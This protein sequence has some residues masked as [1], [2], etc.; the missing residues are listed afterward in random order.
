MIITYLSLYHLYFIFKD[1]SIINNELNRLMD[2]TTT[3]SNCL[4]AL[5]ETRFADPISSLDMNEKY[6]VIGTMMGRII[7]YSFMNKKNILLAE[8][9]SENI[10]GIQFEE[11]DDDCFNLV[12]GDDE[13]L[14]YQ[15][16]TNNNSLNLCT[17]MKIYQTEAE[18]SQLCENSFTMLHKYCLFRITLSQPEECNVTILN[19]NADY[20]IKNIKTFQNEKGFIEMT[21][22]SV[23]FDFDCERFVWVEFLSD[24]ERNIC[25]FN[26][27]ST[28]KPW[29]YLINKAYGHI[30]HIKLLEGSSMLIVRDLN[31]CEI[32]CHDAHF[33]LLKAFTHIGDEVIAIDAILS[34]NDENNS[35]RERNGMVNIQNLQ[36]E[37]RIDLQKETSQFNQINH[38]IVPAKSQLL[39]AIILIFLDVDGNVNGWTEKE[40]IKTLFNLYNIKEI[41]QEEKDKQFFSMGYPYYIKKFNDNFAITSDHGC[42]VIKINN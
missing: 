12:I 11:E 8:H 31:K 1:K 15:L 34:S 17:R 9:S 40:S 24:S 4:I 23:P 20:D 10:T 18:H 30:S 14:K 5:I 41:N 21:N 38:I 37:N 13:I 16:D 29:K 28:E 2:K 26:I 22:Y 3:S 25:V 39:T 6:L 27:N 36:Q 32:R 35:E 42:Y 33:T 7:V 19:K